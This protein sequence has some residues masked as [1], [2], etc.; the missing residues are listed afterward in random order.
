[1]TPLE[2]STRLLMHFDEASPAS[3]VDSSGRRS[4]FNLLGGGANLVADGS[5]RFGSRCYSNVGS[6]GSYDGVRIPARTLPMPRY[7]VPYS[8]QCWVYMTANQP[9]TRVV[10][11][12]YSSPINDYVL[13]LR[14]DS[15]GRV[16]HVASGTILTTT[17]TLPLNQWNL[18]EATRD[19]A[20]TTRV[21]IN[22]VVGV[23]GTTPS[24]FSADYNEA[25]G[26]I[27][28]S[29]SS[30]GSH[31]MGKI[32]ELIYVHNYALNS[33]DYSASLPSAAYG[34]VAF[35]SS[36]A[37]AGLLVRPGTS[38]AGVS[39]RSFASPVSLTDLRFGGRGT[40]AD[41]VLENGTPDTPLRRK[42]WLMRDRDAQIIRETW[43]DAATGNYSF[44]N[45]DETQRYSVLSFDHLRNYRAV[46]ADNLTPTVP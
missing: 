44:T 3:W 12:I 45:I 27:G 38:F 8:L 15:S 17:S 16:L 14:V 34:D 25:D 41:S 36:G 23:T 10:V 6:S 43:S 19:F 20:G 13:D 1:M 2:A 37:A 5:S 46:I 42:V 35:P 29:V 39:P 22:G 30:S 31:F 11:S 28:S 7:G 33:A 40:I 9:S 4:R 24:G 26:A 32:D 21:F 18:I